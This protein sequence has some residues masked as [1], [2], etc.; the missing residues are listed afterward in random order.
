MIPESRAA[1]Q[2][3][4]M[5]RPKDGFT[6]PGVCAFT[7]LEK[8]HQ[9]VTSCSDF[10]GDGCMYYLAFETQV[11]PSGTSSDTLQHSLGS[12]FYQEAVTITI[13]HLLVRRMPISTMRPE[14]N[15]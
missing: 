4:Y 8:E 13:T 5:A 14:W 6:V 2:D 12:I 15:M 1:W 3:N 10:L 9:K 7:Q 11:F